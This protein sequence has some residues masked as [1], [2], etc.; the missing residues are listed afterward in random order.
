MSD[1]NGNPLVYSS[2]ENDLREK[3]KKLEKELNTLKI[4]KTKLT[5]Q[6]KVA[7]AALE[8]VDFLKLTFEKLIADK[9]DREWILEPEFERWASVLKIRDALEALN[10]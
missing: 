5:K 3:I 2:Y 1:E 6:V 8:E 7:K 4:F 10:E 9:P